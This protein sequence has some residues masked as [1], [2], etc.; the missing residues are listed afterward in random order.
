M[1]QILQDHRPASGFTVLA[2][3][4]ILA[5][6]AVP[7]PSLPACATSPY[8]PNATCFGPRQPDATGLM[9]HV[10]GTRLAS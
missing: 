9:K 8:Q 10:F 7:A 2:G 1:V 3:D 5:T 4:L 6:H